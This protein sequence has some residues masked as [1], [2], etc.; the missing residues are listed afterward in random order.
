M[1]CDIQ[2]RS[3]GDVLELLIEQGLDGTAKAISILLNE[4]MR[5]ERE[6]HLGAGPWE[7]SEE[8]QGYA[9]GYKKKS[10]QSRFGKLDLSIPQTRDTDFYPS[11]LERGLRSE[12]ALKLALAEMYV[13]GVST[14]KVAR[15]TEELCGFEISSTQ[16]SR[17]AHELDVQACRLFLL[18]LR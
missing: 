18:E 10:L 7:R 9:N 12:K 6:R 15:V 1:T 4:A 8:R 3:I 16:L 17:A 5:L 13:Q 14:R 11:S 2:D